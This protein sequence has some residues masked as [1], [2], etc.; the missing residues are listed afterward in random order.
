M[1]LVGS[2]TFSAD[3]TGTAVVLN[4]VRPMQ[5]IAF[6][7]SFGGG[8]I[9]ASFSADGGTTYKTLASVSF[10]ANGDA[11]VILANMVQGDLFRVSMGSSTSPSVTV[12]LREVVA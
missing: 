4:H 10:T 12:L 3:G 6:G 5:L 8:T 9:T 11:P 7:S 2:W 1:S